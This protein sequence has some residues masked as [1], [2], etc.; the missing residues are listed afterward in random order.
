M[1]PGRSSN[2]GPFGRQHRFG[3]RRT[4]HRGGRRRGGD[5]YRRR[6]PFVIASS[7]HTHRNE[8]Q[9]ESGGAKTGHGSGGIVLPRA[10]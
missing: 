7:K 3:P 2:V 1:T 6:S 8:V 10:E 4:R 5:R 9:S